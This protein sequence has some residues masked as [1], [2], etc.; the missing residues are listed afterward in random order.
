MADILYVTKIRGMARDTCRWYNGEISMYTHLNERR[1]SYCDH[2]IHSLQY[3]KCFGVASLKA[4]VHAVLPCVYTTSSTDFINNYQDIF[5]SLD[6]TSN[7]NTSSI[8]RYH[9]MQPDINSDSENDNRET[10]ETQEDCLNDEVD[11]AV[12]NEV[13][14]DVDDDVDDE[15]VDD[16]EVPIFKPERD[17]DSDNEYKPRIIGSMPVRRRNSLE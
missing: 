16:A 2:F 9:Y 6:P 7:Y 11:D 10:L 5:H 15:K 8:G 17:S 13:D 12:D 1:I 3:A 14:N 4:V